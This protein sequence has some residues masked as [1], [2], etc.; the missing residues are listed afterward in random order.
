VRFGLL[1]SLEV[2][3]DDGTPID[4]GGAQPRTLLALLLVAAGRVVTADRII[5]VLWGEDPP[6]S[7]SGTLQS[8]VSRLRR[9]LEPNRQKR[10][11]PTVLLYEPPG[12]RLAGDRADVDI[13]RFEALAETGAQAVAAGRAAEAIEALTAA[14]ALWR[15]PALVEYRDQE[16]ARGLAQR[17]EERRLAVIE[18]RIAAGF[19]LGDHAALVGQLRE[20]VDE[21]PLRERLHEQLAIALY[22]TGRQAD[23]LRAIDTARRTLGDELGLEP[24]PALREL[25]AAILAHD[26]AL[27]TSS[28]SVPPPTPTTRVEP[29]PAGP[30]GEQFL[31]RTGEL[32]ELLAVLD[33]AGSATRVAIIEGEPGI[34]KTRL[35]EEVTREAARRGDT[36]LWGRAFEGGAAPAFWPWLP[37]LRTLVEQLSS[38]EPFEPALAALLRSGDPEAAEQPTEGGRF[39]LFE[40]VASLL[41]SAS[42]ERRVVLVLDD[43]QWADVTSLELLTSVVGRLSDAPVLVIC[44]VRELP[45]GHDDA[46]VEALATLARSRGTRRLGLGGLSRSDTAALVQQ[47]TGA[48]SAEAIVAIHERAEGNPFFTTEL[49]RLL[50]AGARP[51]EVPSGVRDTVRRRLALLPAPTLELLQVAAVI[52]RDADLALLSRAGQLSLDDALDRLEPALLTRLLVALEEQP[53]T[54]RFSHALV[55]EAIV[56]DLSPLRRARLHLR[57]ADAYVDDDDTAEI[58]AEHLW[59]AAAIG[60]GR[61]AASALERAATVAVRRL[62]YGSAVDLLDRAVQLRRAAGADPDDVLAEIRAITMYAGA[63]GAHDGYPSLIGSPIVARGRALAEAA[64]D[65]NALI[66]LLWTEWAALDQANQFARSQPI[67]DEL[68]GLTAASDDPLTTVLAHTAVGISCWH[69]GDVR[70]AGHH[71]DVASAATSEVPSAAIL[72][73]LLD[74]DQLLLPV[75]FAVYIR[76][77]QGVLDDPAAAYDEVLQ[78]APGNRY[79]E[80]LVMN[81]AAAGALATGDVERAERAT[82]RALESA[83]LDASFF[84]GLAARCYA[85]IAVALRGE[86]DAGLAMFDE[87]W[88]RYTERG[89]R[90]NGTQ[91]LSWKARALARAGRVAEARAALES[92]RTEL[93]TYQ[94]LF[95]E[96]QV[97]ISE[98]VVEAASGAAPAAVEAALVRAEEAAERQGAHAV[99]AL[100]AALRSGGG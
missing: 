83:V 94:E 57:V 36:V 51:T 99:A 25:E 8:Y 33:E 16:F 85:G 90:T 78:L 5:D 30:S 93:A 49:A 86:V 60:V 7:A 11:Q 31:G 89:I 6:A 23:A 34:G 68:L 22:R 17:L 80:L 64:G 63:R 71:L 73:A 74:A 87:A 39:I 76:D 77:L 32:A 24:G 27:D 72:T 18:D 62:A 59:K 43:L 88:A 46:V 82:S 26:P 70:A 84:W 2:V 44:T 14:E 66:H 45:L 28:P 41:R 55:R 53:G 65:T 29:A 56:G 12:Y 20:L 37:P 38:G 1:G 40:A 91:L 81:F 75:P 92:A 4:V 48:A 3:G 58:I 13:W 50:A 47:A 10:A 96:P 19:M 21:H 67:A 52:G 100:A 15:G 42:A 97:L 95:A 98:A 79:W 61:R 69:R 54:Y 9:E 35:A